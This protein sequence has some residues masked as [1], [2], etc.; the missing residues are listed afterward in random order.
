MTSYVTALELATYLDGTIDEADLSAAWTAKA[1]ALLEDVSADVAAAAGVPIGVASVTATLPGTWSRD[2]E[3]P[4]GPISSITSVTL[5]GEAVDATGYWWNGRNTL[6]RGP[7]PSLELLDDDDTDEDRGGGTTRDVH[8]WGG[9]E[10]TVIV[11]LAVPD[12]VPAIVKALVKRIAARTIG[13][14]AQIT[15][16]SLGPYSVSYGASTNRNDGSHVTAAERR[17][18]RKLLGRSTA[19]T[20]RT[21][22]R[23]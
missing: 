4:D 9:P 15:Q 1:E 14:P 13:N 2:L 10:S 11:V 7:N 8:S 3:L 16:E 12:T 20:F 5:N 23:G 18:L 22:G 21:R 6:R 19:G 17:R